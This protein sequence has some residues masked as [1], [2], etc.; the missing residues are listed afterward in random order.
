MQEDADGSLIVI[1]TGAWYKL[2]CPTSQLAKPDVLGAI[3]R[4]RRKNGPRIED[5]RGLKLNWAGMKPA[6][7]V[8]LLDE[9]RPA[10]RSRAIESLGKQGGDAVPALVAALGTSSSVEARRNAVWALTRIDGTVARAAVRQALNDPE[11]TIRQAAC[12]SSGG[13]A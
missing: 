1:D 9:S 5:P 12:H 4:I 3:Y 10:V 7:L 11:E 13:M 6:E 2:C 8:K